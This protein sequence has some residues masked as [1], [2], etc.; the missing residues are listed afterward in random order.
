MERSNSPQKSHGGI[1]DRIK[2]HSKQD[3]RRQGHSKRIIVNFHQAYM[4]KEI[5]F[6]DVKDSE[7]D[8]SKYQ[9]NMNS[10]N[11]MQIVE[12]ELKVDDTEG[13]SRRKNHTKR[14]ISRN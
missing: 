4:R 6:D 9:S 1:H 8:R 12:A 14:S 10:S 11:H 7:V 13:L 5:N 3:R 2:V